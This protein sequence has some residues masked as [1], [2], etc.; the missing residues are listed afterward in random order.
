MIVVAF[1]IRSSLVDIWNA[2]ASAI[3]IR[4]SLDLFYNNVCVGEN[5]LVGHGRN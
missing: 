5:K 1:C 3:N 4:F 2:N